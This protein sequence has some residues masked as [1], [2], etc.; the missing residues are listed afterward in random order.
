MMFPLFGISQNWNQVSNFVGDGRHHP[1][2]FGNDEYG[3]VICSPTGL[4]DNFGISHWNANFVNYM[5]TV[6]DI[7]FLSSL[8]VFL[9]AILP[10]NFS[11]FF[12]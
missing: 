4:E 2:T 5:T 8:A 1:I 12:A 11:I 3:F 9:F 6:D 7:G 10:S